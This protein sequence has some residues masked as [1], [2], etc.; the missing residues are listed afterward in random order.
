[1]KDRGIGLVEA[2]KKV[3]TRPDNVKKVMR[4]TQVRMRRKGRKV[5]LKKEVSPKLLKKADAVIALMM[6]GR[7]AS[8]AC[9]MAGTTLKKMAD[10]KLAT[11]MGQ[12]RHF[13]KKDNGRWKL[14]LYRIAMYSTVFYGKLINTYGNIMGA[15]DENEDENYA[16]ILWQFD[17]DPFT[18]TL[19]PPELAEHYSPLL[20]QHLRDNIDV[21]SIFDL[22]D[23][24]DDTVECGV[25]DAGQEINY[26][27]KTTLKKRHKVINVGKF[28]IIVNRQDASYHYPDNPKE[29]EYHHSLKDERE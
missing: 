28:E 19:P 13:I 9:K 4:Q 12:N 24:F 17:F 29:I 26:V 1:M 16:H 10:I 11:V 21:S 18:T 15:D 3:G 14:R 7:S 5:Q 25:E 22:A 23:D 20:L 8:K 6:S 27:S 2:S